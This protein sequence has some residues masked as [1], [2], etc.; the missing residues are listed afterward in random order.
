M[1]S[2]IFPLPYKYEWTISY[3]YRVIF[4]LIDKSSEQRNDKTKQNTKISIREQ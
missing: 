3:T 2:V 1:Y 4:S